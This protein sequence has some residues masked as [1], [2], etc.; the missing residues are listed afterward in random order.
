MR[1]CVFAGLLVVGSAAA[2][3]AP[4]T[5][6]GLELKAPISIPECVLD[7]NSRT[8]F[9]AEAGCYKRDQVQN[10]RGKLVDAEGPLGDERAEVYFAFK[11]KP[12]IVSGYKVWTVLRD[13]QIASVGTR[14]GGIRTQ[15]QD[16][17]QLQ[18][19]YG[20]PTRLE[21]QSLQNGAGAKFEGVVAEWELPSG[22]LV[23][24]ESPD[25]L[26]A[27]LPTIGGPNVGTLTVMTASLKAEMDAKREATD[28]QR[29]KL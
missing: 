16:L 28:S 14:T 1:A 3:Q 22:A 10:R 8:Y 6:F 7:K 17:T 11:N 2:Q 27:K 25:M 15:A 21:P 26:L 29:T 12:A 9:P 20:E 4:D 13:G 18:E 19:K 24:L 5:V 23:K